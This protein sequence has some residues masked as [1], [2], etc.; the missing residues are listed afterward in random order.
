[1]EF[2]RRRRPPPG[3]SAMCRGNTVGTNTVSGTGSGAAQ[4]FT[5]FGRVPSQTTPP[6]AT[7]SDTIVTTV[8][9]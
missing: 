3:R 4:N 9:Y 6:P 7:Y 5:V 1:M 2:D 8:T